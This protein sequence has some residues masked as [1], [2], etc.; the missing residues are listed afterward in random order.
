LGTVS[1]VVDR[2]DIKENERRNYED[3]I[4]GMK[5]VPSQ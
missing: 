1:E 3:R 4:I 2:E 5:C